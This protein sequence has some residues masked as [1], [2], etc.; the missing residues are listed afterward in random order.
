MLGAISAQRPG[1]P[2]RDR[3]QVD[4]A[5]EQRD[6]GARDERGRRAAAGCC[7]ARAGRR[8]T[9]PD[10]PALVDLDER[11]GGRR[12]DERPAR[13]ASA[14]FRSQARRRRPPRC[15]R[16]R[17]RARGCSFR[18]ARAIAGATMSSEIGMN[19]SPMPSDQSQCVRRTRGPR[20]RA[21]GPTRDGARGEAARSA[22]TTVRESSVDDEQ[23]R[24]HRAEGE[25]ER[26]VD[27]LHQRPGSRSD[28]LAEEVG[29]RC[30]ERAA[31]RAPRRRGRASP[32]DHWIGSV[33]CVFRFGPGRTV[34]EGRLQLS[35]ATLE[36]DPGELPRARAASVGIVATVGRSSS[37]GPCVSSHPTPW[38]AELPRKRP[39]PK[40]FAWEPAAGYTTGCVPSTRSSLSSPQLACSAPSCWL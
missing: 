10:R 5:D 17:S 8:A 21:S 31:G 39:S 9:G 27:Q 24:A 11:P 6:D 30:S 26:A 7:R 14:R 23:E 37:C 32:A 38:D 1:E 40:K 12:L 4:R 18:A 25:L 3:Q 15:C 34:E 2:D 35:P 22:A 13:A 19:R 29:R 20:L 33:H 36:A 16:C 28:R